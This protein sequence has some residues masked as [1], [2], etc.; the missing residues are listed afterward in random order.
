MVKYKCRAKGK[1]HIPKKPVKVGCCGYLRNFQVYDGRTAVGTS[2]SCSW[3]NLLFSFSL[4]WWC[5]IS[6]RIV[7]V[8]TSTRQRT[9]N[10]VFIAVTPGR[11]QRMRFAWL[12]SLNR[13]VY[14]TTAA[15]CLL[16]MMSAFLFIITLECSVI[17]AMMW[18]IIHEKNC[19]CY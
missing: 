13:T 17:V 1:V 5:S 4:S 10:R 12:L 7:T 6:K 3:C 8:Y 19:S 15:E 9:G 14:S 18:W 11:I 2:C 16:G